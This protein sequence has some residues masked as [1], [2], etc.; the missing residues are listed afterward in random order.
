MA[1]DLGWTLDADFADIQEAQAAKR[2]QEAPVARDAG[3][4]L[5]RFRYE[6]PELPY[7]TCVSTAGGGEWRATSE[8]IATHLTLSTQQ[9]ATV[10]IVVTPHDAA[11]PVSVE[12]A[13]EREHVWA[14][15]PLAESA[16]Y[17]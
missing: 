14:A 17:C 13:A 5:L 16:H 8:G 12:A 7:E 1:L 15:G 10:A 4:C 11:D 3:G 6:H 2:Q 9:T